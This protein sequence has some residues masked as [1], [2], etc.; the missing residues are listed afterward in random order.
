ML[1]PK[2]KSEI[3]L[4]NTLISQIMPYLQGEAQYTQFTRRRIAAQIEDINDSY[5]YNVVRFF[6]LFSIGDVSG[7]SFLAEQSIGERPHDVVSWGNY[8]LCSMYTVGLERALELAIRAV[9]LTNSPRMVRDAFYYA[10]GLGDFKTFRK[11]LDRYSSMGKLDFELSDEDNAALPLAV[12]QSELAIQS[13]LAEDIANVGKIMNS[14]L[15]PAMQIDAP[16]NFYLLEDED[17]VT[18]VLEITPPRMT[19]EQCADL[20][21][22]L[23]KKRVASGIVNWE[24]VGIFANEPTRQQDV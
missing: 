12:R 15:Q 17:S 5:Y 19:P 6:F 18:C 8:I 10:R 22:A 1:P 24:V 21:I 13:G 2:P 7:G 14:M 23:I 9:E 16:V 20:N 11:Y 3:Q 4:L